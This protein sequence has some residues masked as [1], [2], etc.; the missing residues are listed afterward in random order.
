[1]NHL[2]EL[3]TAID[4]D[5]GRD[6]HIDEADADRYFA[7]LESQG[8]KAVCF[9]MGDVDD[10][11]ELKVPAELVRLPFET[12]WFEGEAAAD[13]AGNRALIGM[14]ATETPGEAHAAEVFVFMRHQHRWALMTACTLEHSGGIGVSGNDRD[15]LS[16]AQYAMYALK[17]FCCA[18]NCTNVI[19]RE[20]APDLALQKARA[21]KGK[22]PLFSFW[23]LE[24]NGRGEDGQILGGSHASPRVHLVRGHP[25]Q[26]EPG[27]WTWVQ[28]HARGNRAL[29]VVHKDYTAGPALLVPAR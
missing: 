16:G 9:W 5:M 7:Y 24:L 17:A 12:C 22:A 13:G 2:R 26:Y 25:R 1:M 15:V 14:L 3:L 8:E 6:P 11:C 21:K 4:V 10:V 19:R 18:I 27:K 29:G 20:H 28:A 23:T